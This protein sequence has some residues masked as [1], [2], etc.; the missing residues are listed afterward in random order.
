VKLDFWQD[1]AIYFILIDRFY[2]G[3][4]S[5]DNFGKGEY[6]LDDDLSFQGGDLKGIT[7]KLPFIKKMGFDAIWITPPV[8]NQ[9]INPYTPTRGYH[10]YWTYDFTKVDPHFGTLKDYKDL[11]KTAHALGIKVIQDIVVN[12]TGNF[13]T[14]NEKNYDPSHPE[15][16]W[17]E[18]AEAYPPEGL[19]KAPNDPVFKLNNPNIKE[20][21]TAAVYNFTPNIS[22]FKD[23]KQTLTYTMGDLDDINLHSPIAANRLK[24]IYRYWIDE[25][26]VD[27][28]RVDT[29]YYTPE[30]FYENFLFDKDPNNLG[31]KRFAENKGIKD[32]FAFGEAWSYDY[33]AINQ[34]LHDGATARLDSAVD[35]A[36]CEA[37]GQVFYGGAAT[38]IAGAS[39]RAI[40]HNRN[41]WINFLDN[42]DIERMASKAAW[43]SIKQSLIALFTLPGIPC[44]YYG[45][46]AGFETLRQNMFSDKYF[47]E[48]SKQFLLLKQLIEFRKA[49]PALRRGTCNVEKT[50]HTR[51]V[52]SYCLSHEG[53]N[54]L[55]VFNTSED[56]MVY[57]LGTR[58][59][60]FEVL[61]SSEKARSRNGVFI[62][63]PRSHHVLKMPA[64]QMTSKCMPGPSIRRLSL[65]SEACQGKIQIRFDLSNS[66]VSELWLLPNYDYARKIKIA[67]VGL[68]RFEFDTAVLGNGTHTINLLAKSKSKALA[69]SEDLTVRVENPYKMIASCIVSTENKGGIGGKIHPPA[70]PSYD[71]QV[72][73]ESAEVSTS[74]KDL[75]LT[76]KMANV[77]NSWNSPNGY[78]HVYFNVLLDF[79]GQSGKRIFPKMDYRRDDF[80]F[81]LGFMIY[82]WGCRSFSAK[83]ST[84][85]SYGSP[86]DGKVAQSVD[87]DRKTITFTFSA[88]HFKS[89]K[90]FHGTKLF[91]STWDG[92]LGDFRTICDHKE[93][94]N[95]Y[96]V[97]S[98]I[99]DLP[100]VFDYAII[101]L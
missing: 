76:L 50:S 82:G 23:R 77:T 58:L 67:D 12:H 31:V 79:P 20:H 33:E 13:F 52:F 86:V 10:G 40:R 96:V 7:Q 34:Y 44:I 66:Q 73:M 5:N 59:D 92:Y 32:F 36:L 29:V 14:I 84:K 81:N 69:M 1:R 63:E 97:N 100:K 71:G 70:D 16:N 22:D 35:L 62:L 80:K 11:V 43:P 15:L 51:G 64:N 53:E 26:G 28:F 91:I 57:D 78:D 49:H 60:S 17:K 37:L 9:W 95:F 18:L 47:N 72:S 54:I 98:P 56:K 30:D 3:D 83:D 65:P 4:K 90:S 2:N 41:L 19:P 94:W 55:V 87:L 46:E 75:R 25:V 68:G 21:K 38:D 24:E 89:V 88:E 45:T 74:G 27:G 8:Y 42:H 6:N 85:D 48:K 39:L 99:N 101:H 93:A 61:L